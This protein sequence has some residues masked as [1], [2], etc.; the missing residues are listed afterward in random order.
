M[1]VG[2]RIYFSFQKLY[3]LVLVGIIF[4]SNVHADNSS[5]CRKFS[6]ADARK[7]II[8]SLRETNI[9]GHYTNLLRYINF[10]GFPKSVISSMDG[11]GVCWWYS[12]FIRAAS[13]LA[14]FAP[15]KKKLTSE[16][17]IREVILKIIKMN[18]VV[19]IP[20]YQNL[21]D[22]HTDNYKYLQAEL[23]NWQTRD[24]LNGL[25]RTINWDRPSF[26]L[27]DENL[28]QTFNRLHYL[29]NAENV[30]P[31]VVEQIKGIAAH[32]Y[33]VIKSEKVGSSIWNSKI[34]LTLADSNPA[35][36]KKA[37]I[38]PSTGDRIL[39]LDY[40]TEEVIEVG[41][42]IY[43]DFNRDLYKIEKALKQHC[44]HT[45]LKITPSQSLVYEY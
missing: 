42:A 27:Y 25:A 31:F 26:N 16:K 38:D 28:H 17:E 33:L 13:Y 21:Y 8:S 3:F 11:W 4:S 24:A 30:M 40:K 19:E 22:F 18:H 12:R 45:N 15:E 35:F 44:P 2:I 5:F 6:H 36:L 32:S 1:P 20:G 29:I 34:V 7:K 39:L 43:I 41:H 14:K 10:G 37:I 9:D 23:N